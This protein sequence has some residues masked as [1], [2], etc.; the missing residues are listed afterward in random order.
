MLYSII[1]FIL[2][3]HNS[4]ENPLYRENTTRASPCLYHLF[5][6]L[7]LLNAQNNSQII[8]DYEIIVSK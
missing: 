6:V 8:N 1:V 2:I 5:H 4:L 7:F 3:T